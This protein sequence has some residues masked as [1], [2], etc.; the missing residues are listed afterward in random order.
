M[1]N[2]SNLLLLSVF[3]VLALIALCGSAVSAAPP[4]PGS[5]E[6]KKAY[7]AKLAICKDSSKEDRCKWLARSLVYYDC[8]DAEDSCAFEGGKNG[9]MKKTFDCIENV[10]GTA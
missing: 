8:I 3:A 5:P 2:S 1:S 10:V 6:A 4:K 7:E 9:C